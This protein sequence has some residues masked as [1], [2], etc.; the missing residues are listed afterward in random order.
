MNTNH[1]H[2]FLTIVEHAAAFRLAV[3][4]VRNRIL[5]GTWPAR[6]VKIG[7]NILI[8]AVE[9]QRVVNQMLIQAGIDQ[10]PVA[11]QKEKKRGRPRS[12]N[13]MNG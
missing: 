8:P 12:I 3:N 10:Q 9:H 2:E 6:T 5:S 13:K 4:T 11:I 1:D 7:K